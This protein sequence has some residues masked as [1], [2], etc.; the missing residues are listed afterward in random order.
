MNLKKTEKYAIM[1]IYVYRY[2]PVTSE[3]VAKG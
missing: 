2:P 3:E 1:L